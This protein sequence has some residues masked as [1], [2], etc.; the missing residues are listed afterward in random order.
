[1]RAHRRRKIRA[2]TVGAA[3]IARRAA[4][5]ELTP[6]QMTAL[7]D[8]SESPQL[9]HAAT[10]LARLYVIEGH[11]RKA[12]KLASTLR[13]E[14]DAALRLA[15]GQQI[16]DKAVDAAFAALNESVLKEVQ[17]LLSKPEL[18][19]RLEAE[20]VKTVGSLAAASVRNTDL[21]RDITDLEEFLTFEQDYRGQV[22]SLN[23]TMKLPHAGTTRQ[24]PYAQLFVEPRVWVGDKRTKRRPR[25]DVDQLPVTAILK[26]STRAVV[27]GDPGGGKSTL[28]RKLT[29]DLAADALVEGGVRRTP[30][31]VELRDYAGSVRGRKRRTLVEYLEGLC[32]SPYNIEA[33]AQAIE[34]MLLNDRAV[35][36]LD[37]LD[38][39]LDT[40]LRRDVVEAVEGF[41]HRYP[42]CPML[43][44]SRRIG[45]NE[46][47]LDADLF[48]AIQ[49]A[50]FDERQVFDYVHKWFTLDETIDTAHQEA[51]A[52]SFMADS[53][54]VSDLRVNPLM[55]S[56]MCGI[57][58]SENYIPRN[59]PDVYEKC[60]LLLFDRWDKQRGIA[61]P[62]SFDAHVQAAMR[63][64][65]L[66][67]Y[68][69]DA[70]G[71]QPA[72][73][74]S[75]EGIHR[76]KLVSYM[77]KYLRDKR[78]ES[79]EEA[80]TAAT[81]FIDFCK[82]R[83]W[84]LTDVGADTY[85][86]T[87][88]T[89]LEYFAA[90]QLVR[91][92]TSASG[93]YEQLR[94][95]IRSGGWDV[96]AQLAVQILGRATEDGAD[97]FL[98]LVLND[99]DGS[100]DADF[101]AA[102]FA[103][104]AMQFVVPRP[105]I[106]HDV[107]RHAYKLHGGRSDPRPKGDGK[108]LDRELG[109][110]ILGELMS[111]SAENA[112]RVGAVLRELLRER[113]AANKKDRIALAVALGPL[114]RFTHLGSSNPYWQTWAGENL[115]E[116]SEEI[117]V[118]APS[119]PWIAL[120]ELERS[121]I[122]VED[123][124]EWHGMVALYDFRD[125]DHRRHGA[126]PP[127]FYQFLM[128]RR[129]A[130]FEG[131]IGVVSSKEAARIE[132]ALAKVLPAQPVPWVPPKAI[133]LYW[134]WTVETGGVDI[135]KVGAVGILLLL[136][137]LEARANSDFKSGPLAPWAKVLVDAR[138]GIGDLDASSDLLANLFGEAVQERD[139]VERWARG[140]IDLLGE[141]TR[142]RR[143]PAAAHAAPGTAAEG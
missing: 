72:G 65:A 71:T 121:R 38:E 90:S 42:T 127:F 21:L 125:S 22:A 88:R 46:A 86:F 8:F 2:L 89:F 137:V 118:A 33:P 57:Y 49:L 11:G 76:T 64:L 70:A 113:L 60:A 95:H 110:R 114:D 85:G 68:T 128:M 78:F 51:L 19:P 107:V 4:L 58:A 44:T 30:F 115:A 81:E 32:K 135:H 116:F 132:A 61:A 23:A 66:Y 133:Q 25:V 124:L 50:E 13:L 43:V 67:M 73:A 130:G 97:D 122:S 106:I 14:F 92:H 103:V 104:R 47:P 62:L 59:R 52:R 63:S 45:Y 29:H 136:P 1:M 24:V 39:L 6:N 143:R 40:D 120:I 12:D 28:S 105:V 84:V 17:H 56:L 26:R 131:T 55:L 48:P 77:K 5:E 41:A 108:T 93:L 82:G 3:G 75:P 31:L 74:D 96:I 139:F 80:E 16:D 99:I 10:S 83:A 101:Y 54:F 112:P 53:V 129:R 98:E 34:W 109:V 134:Q 9:E 94:P 111:V 18:A 37:G 7:L 36:I 91:E 27:L 140:E 69:L 117:R 126:T 119:I 79:D 87:H 15:V 102:S 100:T 123:V 20:M 141:A 142:R 138:S 35:V